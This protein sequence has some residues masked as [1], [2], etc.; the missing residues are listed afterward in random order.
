MVVSEATHPHHPLPVYLSQIDQTVCDEQF[1][2]WFIY[3]VQD[4]EMTKPKV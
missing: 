2:C 1:V 4:E 3:N